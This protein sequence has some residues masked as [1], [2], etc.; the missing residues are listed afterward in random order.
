MCRTRKQTRSFP[1]AGRT[2]PRRE[3]RC[4]VHRSRTPHRTSGFAGCISPD[5]KQA[6]WSRLYWFLTPS[7]GPGGVWRVLPRR[8]RKL[9]GRAAPGCARAGPVPTASN[10]SHSQRVISSA[11]SHVCVG[12]AA[13]NASREGAGLSRPISFEAPVGEVP[14]PST[15]PRE[16]GDMSREGCPHLQPHSSPHVVIALCPCRVGSGGPLLLLS[17]PR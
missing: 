16:W 14:H 5:Q 13:P 1:R 8:G 17:L 15:L 7:R 10:R 12:I 4:A 11:S 6:A 3:T 9:R 2:S